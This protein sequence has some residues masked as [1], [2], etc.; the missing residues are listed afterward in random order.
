MARRRLV[1]V[2]IVL[3]LAILGAG[4]DALCPFPRPGSGRART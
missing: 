2:V 4:T 1:C 3:V